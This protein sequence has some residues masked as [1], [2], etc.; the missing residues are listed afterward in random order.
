MSPY[1][2]VNAVRRGQQAQWLACLVLPALAL[3]SFAQSSAPSSLAAGVPI[4]RELSGGQSHS[5]QVTLAQGQYLQISVEQRGCDVA[6]VLRGADGAARAEADFDSGLRG[7][8]ILALV[9]TAACNCQLEVRSKSKTAGRYILKIEALRA[10]TPHDADRVAAYRLQMEARKLQSQ[11]IA[12]AMQQAVGKY[13]VALAAW[14]NL[15]DQAGQA[16]ALLEIGELHFDLADAKKAFEATNE[17]LA[18]WRTLGR[19]TEEAWALSND[20]FEL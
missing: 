13:A 17:A 10:A 2:K 7:Q 19:R 14:K 18:L 1:K 12:E 8:E 6:V 9:T 11:G 20:D 4:T 15:G 5:Y 16:E 3:F